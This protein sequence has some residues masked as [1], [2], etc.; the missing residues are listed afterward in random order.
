MAVYEH[1]KTSATPA[2]SYT[3]LTADTAA[4]LAAHVSEPNGSSIRELD[5]AKRIYEIQDGT[6]YEL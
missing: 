4:W 2:R 5:G 3:C 1:E 6:W